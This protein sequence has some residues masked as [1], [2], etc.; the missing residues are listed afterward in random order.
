MS[1]K[2][3]SVRS[4]QSMSGNFRGQSNRSFKKLDK[5]KIIK[6]NIAKAARERA[7][8]RPTLSERMYWEG[9]S[10]S[11]RSGRKK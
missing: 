2:G 5:V 3:C 8:R 10:G 6:E 4:L 7:G 11:G 9:K 1:L